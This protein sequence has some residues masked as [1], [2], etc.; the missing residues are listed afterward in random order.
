MV[1]T[2]WFK[3]L[4][5]CSIYE[6]KVG[7]KLVKMKFFVHAMAAEHLAFWHLDTTRIL[8][9]SAYQGLSVHCTQARVIVR[10]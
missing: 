4:A 3:I 10:S 5:L 1:H 8:P 2:N 7:I 6:F 9:T